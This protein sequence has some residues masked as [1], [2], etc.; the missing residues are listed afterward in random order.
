MRLLT[1]VLFIV[2]FTAVPLAAQDDPGCAVAD[3]MRLFSDAAVAID[4]PFLDDEPEQLSDMLSYILAT[5]QTRRASC[6]GLAFEGEDSQ[7]IGPFTLPAGDYILEVKFGGI[8]S[9]TAESLTEECE[10]PIGRLLLS[11]F[12][13][14]GGTDSSILRT[15]ADCRIL[16]DVG[17]NRPWTLTFTPVN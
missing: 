4:D 17:I 12:D 1:A 5:I 15:D 3:Y 6:A 11:S 7:I 2:L 13:R 8:G 10:R 9:V 16:I 14:E